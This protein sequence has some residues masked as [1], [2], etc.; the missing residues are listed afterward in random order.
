MDRTLGLYTKKLRVAKTRNPGKRPRQT[1][2]RGCRSEQRPEAR[3]LRR[4]AVRR[5]R[6]LGPGSFRGAPGR[7]DT[8]RSAPAFDARTSSIAQVRLPVPNR[9][10]PTGRVCDRD[11]RGEARDLG[12]MAADR[13]IQWPVCRTL[14]DRSATAARPTGERSLRTRQSRPVAQGRPL[15]DRRRLA[16]GR[17][18]SGA[19]AN[20]WGG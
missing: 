3:A 13:V 16:K 6:L 8:G 1:H 17:E 19:W 4:Q 9:H 20:R 11:A 7:P 5:P 14:S 18:N 2:A 15:C 10:A 12:H